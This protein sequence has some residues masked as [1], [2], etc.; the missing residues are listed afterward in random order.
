MKLGARIFSAVEHHRLNYL[1]S[2]EVF[3][4][5][6]GALAAIFFIGC[7]LKR[8]MN[9]NLYKEGL[10]CVGAGSSIA[11]CNTFYY[12]QQYL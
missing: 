9:S 12:K 1:Y 8:P 3:P 2:F 11:F 6:G 7:A 10:C 4:Y 5:L